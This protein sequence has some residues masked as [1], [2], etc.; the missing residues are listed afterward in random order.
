[1]PTNPAN[2]T[3]L[4]AIAREI[5]GEVLEG[6]L[7]YPSETGNWQLGDVDLGEHLDR[8]R[9]RPMMVVL[10]PLGD[11]ESETFTCGVCG[12]VVDS[13]QACPRCKM[14]LDEA[15]GEYD[16]QM[17]EREDLFE[18]IEDFLDGASEE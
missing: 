14:M 11:A 12:L 3:E 9:D 18:D 4:A 10:V 15:I 2:A 8:Y 6:D 13:L 17:Q 1:M 7:R 5:G 16:R